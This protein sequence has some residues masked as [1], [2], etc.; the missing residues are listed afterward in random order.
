VSRLSNPVDRIAAVLLVLVVLAVGALVVRDSGTTA[1]AVPNASAGTRTATL[2]AAGDI[3][4]CDVSSDER[5]AKQVERQPGTLAI[6]GDDAYE[7]GSPSQ[8]KN[9]YDPS[10]GRFKSRTRP[11]VGNHEYHEP[12]AHGYFDYFGKAAGEPGQ[13]WY[14]YDLGAWHVIVLNSNCADVGGCEVGSQQQQWLT[15]DL[16]AHQRLCTLAYWH[17]PR[18]S[19]GEHGSDVEL[20]DIWKTLYDYSADVVLSGHDHDYERFA[21]Q[22][23]DGRLDPTGG[24]RQFVVGTGGRSHYFI[25]Q[26]LPH[27]EAHKSDTFGVLV[28]TLKADGY[29]WRFDAEPGKWFRDYGSGR[30]H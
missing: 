16:L 13:G 6:L 21:P 3:A 14:S 25:R 26:V 23:P 11:S 20:E 28:L 19:S 18:F 2:I 27:S 5:V 9:C 24:I 1:G 4:S 12:G 8:F 22:T 17:H 7:D 29:D 10:W 30:C 15:E